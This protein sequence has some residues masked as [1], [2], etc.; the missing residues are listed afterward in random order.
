MARKLKERTRAGGTMTEAQL[1]AFIINMIRQKTTLWKP[2]QQCRLRNRCGSVVNPDTGRS[3]IASKCEECA[4]IEREKVGTK[5][6]HDV[7]HEPPVVPLDGWGD[8]TSWL[9]INWNEYLANTFAEQD[10]LRL[11][12]KPCHKE[13]TKIENTTR[14]ENDKKKSN[15]D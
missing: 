4:V 7:D 12:C 15:M 14:R 11:L 13:T 6:Q 3:I 1:K 9:G 10:K 8:T 5:F 2:N